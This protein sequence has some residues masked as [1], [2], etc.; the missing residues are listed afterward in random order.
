MKACFV[1]RKPETILIGK[2]LVSL[3][4]KVDP[5]M[6]DLNL[7]TA[8]L[9]QWARILALAKILNLMLTAKSS[10]ADWKHKLAKNWLNFWNL[11]IISWYNVHEAIINGTTMPNNT[12]ILLPVQDGAAN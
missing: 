10:L 7:A 4:P 2:T 3:Y 9:D 6:S 12:S 8:D 5:S 1:P 11:N